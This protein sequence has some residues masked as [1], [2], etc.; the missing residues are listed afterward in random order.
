[1]APKFVAL[2][3]ANFMGNDL[4]DQTDTFHDILKGLPHKKVTKH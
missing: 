4:I 2:I 3:Y 1:M